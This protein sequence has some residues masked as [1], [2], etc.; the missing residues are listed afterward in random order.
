M[1]N[2]SPQFHEPTIKVVIKA[3]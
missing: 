2:N 1:E 3:P